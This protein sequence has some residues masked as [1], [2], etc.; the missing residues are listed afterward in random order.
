MAPT[1]ANNKINNDII[2]H[3]NRLVYIILPIAIISVFSINEPSHVL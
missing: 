2:S 3:I 1:I